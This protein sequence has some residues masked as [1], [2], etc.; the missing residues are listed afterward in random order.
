MFLQLGLVDSHGTYGGACGCVRSVRADAGGKGAEEASRRKSRSVAG[1]KCSSIALDILPGE[2]DGA[3]GP[4][5]RPGDRRLRARRRRPPSP[6]R[7]PRPPSPPR[8]ATRS[9]PKTTPM[10]RTENIPEDM[11]EKAKLKRLDY[12]SDSRD[13]GRTFSR[14][15]GVAEEAQSDGNV[16]GGEQITVPNVQVV[17][18]AEGKPVPNITVKVSK[19]EL[20]ADG[21]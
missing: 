4:N 14:V 5:T 1:C 6:K 2:I 3:D 18:A 7:S 15:P 16:R 19:P 21:Y 10:P 20:H 11:M 12:A 8:S 13:A 17:S 9:P